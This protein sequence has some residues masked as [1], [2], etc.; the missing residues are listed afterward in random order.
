MQHELGDEACGVLSLDSYY[1]DL[2]HLPAEERK[3]ANFDQPAA[4]D[5]DR[6]RS[7][8]Q[9]LKSGFSI[10]VPA[11][12]FAT[13]SRR[14]EATSFAAM[15]V[16]LIEGIFVFCFPEISALLDLRIYVDVDVEICLARRLARDVHDRGRDE[17]GVRAQ[18]D[19]WVRPSMKKWVIPQKS[20]ADLVLDGTRPLGDLVA[21]ALRHIPHRPR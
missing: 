11:Y 13:H 20:Q 7:D 17:A 1:C 5:A 18:F 9:R 12:D 2:G 21:L 3:N 6:M 8:L 4:L 10:E 15:P 19:R 14:P 16:V